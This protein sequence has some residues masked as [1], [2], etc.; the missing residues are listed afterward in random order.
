MK[1]FHTP[2][3][4]MLGFIDWIAG[5]NMPTEDTAE[6]LI[7]CGEWIVNQMTKEGLLDASQGSDS[8]TV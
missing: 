5:N 2:K 3:S 6:W 7:R 8:S 4:D 1:S